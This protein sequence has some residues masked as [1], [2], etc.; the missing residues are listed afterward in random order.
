MKYSHLF[1]LAGLGLILAAGIQLSSHAARAQQPDPWS[2]Q[3]RI[4]VYDDIT[5]ERPPFLIADQNRTV[6][7][8]NTQ[9][10]EDGVQAI[11]YRQWTPDSGWMRPID[12]LLNPSGNAIEVLDVFLDQ[13]GVV[14]MA[15]AMDSDI[16]YAAAPLVHAGR[17]SAWTAPARIGGQAI[18]PFSA[19]LVGDDHGNLIAAYAGTQQGKGLYALYSSDAGD[20]WSDPE[21]I[22]LTYEEEQPVAEIQMC[23]GAS[24]QAH[25]V[26]TV[27]DRNGAGVSGHYARWDVEHRRWSEPVP[28][29]TVG[30]GG[31]LNLGIRFPGIAEHGSDLIVTYYHGNVNGNWW[32]RSQDGGQTWSAPVRVSSRHVGTNGALSFAVDSNN[33]LHAFFGQRVDDQNHGMWHITWEGSGWSDAT[34]VVR[35]AQVRDRVGGRGF[36]PKSASAAI[37]QGNMALVTWITDGIAGEN[38]AWYSYRLL[39]APE[40][41]V[42][43]PSMPPTTATAAPTPTP[44]QVPPGTPSPPLATLTPARS[45]STGDMGEGGQETAR[46]LTLPLAAA[47]APVAAFITAVILVRQFRLF[48]RD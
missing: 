31:L 20:T 45:L 37:S 10:I 15:L 18:R 21:P 40:L 6:H 12:V 8:F 23:M 2:P 24:G 13:A 32:R 42:V 17:A 38:G 48:E 5:E 28:L 47:L 44:T 46:N 19:A 36:D 1:R 41:P 7:A 14:H 26:W 11:V 33:T 16:Y 30:E 27:V 3:A 43:P 39:D 34:P 29:D 25:A 35:G 9:E 4:P 22:F